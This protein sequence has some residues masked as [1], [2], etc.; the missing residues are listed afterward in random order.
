LLILV[1]SLVAA[2]PGLVQNYI[3]I[4]LPLPLHWKN[5]SFSKISFLA[6]AISFFDNCKE[7]CPLP[8]VVN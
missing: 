1:L 4:N 6:S 7:F 8:G 3:T 2:L 5:N